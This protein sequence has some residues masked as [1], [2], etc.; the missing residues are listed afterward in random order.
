MRVLGQGQ[1]DLFDLAFARLLDV[2]LASFRVFFYK[3][4][5]KLVAL[6]CRAARIDKSVLATVFNLSRQAH[7][8][9][10]P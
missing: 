3:D 7:Q 10:A 5:V 6:A 1:I 8:Y 4:G 9:G 2:E